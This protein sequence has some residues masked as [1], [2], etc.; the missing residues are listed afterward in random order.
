LNVTLVPA[1]P[2]ATA[3][4]STTTENPEG[5]RGLFL[6]RVRVTFSGPRKEIDILPD[7][8]R[9]SYTVSVPK[10]AS[11]IELREEM[12]GFPRDGVGV[13]S[14]IPERIELVQEPVKELEI[15]NLHEFVEVTPF[16]Q[17]VEVS[18]EI[19][20]PESKSIRL[21]VPL[22]LEG[23]FRPRIR[24]SRPRRDEPLD[25]Y[26]NLD[27]ESQ[28]KALV[29]QT[30]TIFDWD[31]QTWVGVANAP[32]IH[33]RAWLNEELV[34]LDNPAVRVTF[35]V[36]LVP[37]PI[38]IELHDVAGDTI[39]VRFIGPS[40]EIQRLRNKFRD[41][42]TFSLSVLVPPFDSRTGGTFTFSEGDL[43]LP[44]FPA[45]R[46]EQHEDRR[47]EL[48]TAWSYDI[49]VREAASAGGE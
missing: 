16:Q 25:G 24:I 34:P 33:L 10:D 49:K 19:V 14:F 30:V 46:I 26:F 42:P 44:G 2:S 4:V 13:V 21:R 15:A 35:R 36:P 28:Q 5:P 23:A 37:N 20:K 11:S 38:K 31:R 18:R 41:E 39:P 8:I 3:I 43:E 17:G 32:K 9:R 22:S 6:G 27:F 1:D 47:R 29:E 7:R 12:I 48:K 40:R 45:V